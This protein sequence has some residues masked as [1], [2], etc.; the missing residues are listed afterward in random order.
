MQVYRDITAPTAITH[1]VLAAFISSDNQ[2]LIVIKSASLLQIYQFVA[3]ESQDL[4]VKSDA[5]I[6]SQW[7][8]ENNENFIGDIEIEQSKTS[9]LT[10]LELISEYSLSGSVIGLSTVKTSLDESRDYL[11]IAFESAKI[12]L[13][14]WDENTNGVMTISLHYYEKHLFDSMLNA[15]KPER[16]SFLRT[17]PGNFCSCLKFGRDMFA[18]LPI[19]REDDEEIF[20]NDTKVDHQMEPF[21][22]LFYP[23]FVISATMLDENII[24][25]IDAT[26]L[27]Q[28]REPT[29]AVLY[30]PKRT[31]I[32]TIDKLKDTTALI[33]VALD[34]YQR[35]STPILS[36]TSLPYDLKSL[37]A[38]PAPITG[39]LILGANEIIHVDPA[40]RALGVAVNAAAFE[41]SD[42]ELNDRSFLEIKLEGSQLAHLQNNI[43][44]L[45]LGSGELQ[46]LEFIMDGRTV[47]GIE[48]HSLESIEKLIGSTVSCIAAY[49]QKRKIFFGSKEADGV[50][51]GWR[52]LGETRVK[53]T[54]AETEETAIRDKDYDDEDE[55]I[56]GDSASNDVTKSAIDNLNGEDGQNEP[57]KQFSF[58]IHDEIVNH[59]PLTNMAIGSVNTFDKSE[60]TTSKLEVV[61]ARA[62]DHQ[63]GGLSIFRRS[64]SAS[65]IGKVFIP[66]CLALWTVKTKSRNTKTSSE[67]A[68]DQIDK[69]LIVS[70]ED[71][72]LIFE[73]GKQFE[74]VR[75]S[76]FDTKSP[77]VS[78]GSIFDGTRIVQICPTDIRVYDSEL[79]IVQMIPIE[80]EE[81]TDEEPEVVFASVSENAVL[82][83]LDNGC[84]ILY[85]GDSETLELQETNSF[86]G[87]RYTAGTI[88]SMSKKY[89]PVKDKAPIR[90]TRKRKRPQ[91]SKTDDYAERISSESEY[92]CILISSTQDLIIY[93][94]SDNKVL[95]TVSHVNDLP[96]VIQPLHAEVNSRSVLRR[97]SSGLIPFGKNRENKCQIAEVVHSAL[98]DDISRQN[99]LIFRTMTND[100]VIY[101][102]FI[103]SSSLRTEAVHLAFRKVENPIITRAKSEDLEAEGN[104]T[105]ES[106]SRHGEE[107]LQEL[108]TRAKLSRFQRLITLQDVT[109]F[110]V[111]CFLGEA[112]ANSPEPYWIIK[113]TKSMPKLIPFMGGSTRY[114][115]AFNSMSVDRGFIYARSNGEI[116]ICQLSRDFSYETSWP[117]KKIVMDED[118]HSIAYFP[119]TSM[120]VLSVSTKSPFSTQGAFDEKDEDSNAEL[121]ESKSEIP[122]DSNFCAMTE[123]GSL[124]LVSPISWITVDTFEFMPNEVA[125]TVKMV[126]LQVSEQSKAR[127]QYMAVGTGIFYGEDLPAKG[128]V[129]IFE[130]IE[131]VP[132]PGKPEHNHKLKL[133]VKED[134][135]GVVSTLCDVEGYL[136]AAQGQKVM[137]RALREDNSFLPVAFMDMN[138]YV[139]EAKCIRNVILMGDIMKSVW[140][141]GFSEEPYK[142]QLFGKDLQ[143]VEVSSADFIINSE[144][145]HFVVADANKK[146]HIL[147]YDPEDPRSVSGQLL[148]RKSEFYTGHVI[149]SMTMIPKIYAP[150][151]SKLATNDDGPG[152]SLYSKMGEQY[153]CLGVTTSG[154]LVSITPISETQYRRLFLVQQQIYERTDHIAGLNPRMHRS[155]FSKE[156]VTGSATRAMLDGNMIFKFPSLNIDRQLDIIER[157]GKGGE[158]EIWDYFLE[159]DRAL[160]YM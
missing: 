67:S 82:I 118:V 113:T 128:Y 39:T 71:E 54:L 96:M 44:L 149:E 106:P 136:L 103:I 17:D 31:W 92:V 135:R 65:V 70:M 109:G 14:G 63:T 8:I 49:P 34:L 152:S 6:Q 143:R 81:N 101:Q 132:E 45:I 150:N 119:E 142:M 52:K 4:G 146:I 16:D 19:R 85:K 122:Q 9:I 117:S 112:T 114:L 78:V 145:V 139:T 125:L 40:G 111:V 124:K 140:F 24:N 89:F 116:R 73:I 7:Q 86:K 156:T 56:Y 93:R 33:V 60:V 18:F 36:V 30:Q 98:G 95:Y 158:S 126:S 55:D 51:L 120:Y 130:I 160:S 11:L 127:R 26:F 75:N 72:S 159:L 147:Q 29:L 123:H 151:D 87:Q 42:F 23:S 15:D 53:A 68:L 99:Y 138:M 27:Y 37:Y 100:I 48:I 80:N 129:Y 155:M 134:A 148:I 76:E 77:T 38:L 154:N 105:S 133:I 13:I 41:S 12:S 69:Y 137:V 61:G 43:V 50:L 83:L 84:A 5:E 62:G 94:L 32:G 91:S 121:D 79:Q 58:S 64:I 28:Y 90:K 57:S 66:Q 108:K 35:A 107:T 153:M 102:P 131:I 157:S 20:N 21:T 88:T 141:V 3:H 97:K 2:N 104:S 115:S 22:R 1:C 144:Q 47:E 46:L 25:V 74:E 10:K 110:S 59:G